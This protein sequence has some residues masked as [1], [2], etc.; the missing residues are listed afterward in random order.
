MEFKE[1][2][3][4]L[5]VAERQWNDAE[6]IFEDAAWHQLQAARARVDAVVRWWSNG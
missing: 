5:R 1:A 4:M 3:E 2:I 6:P